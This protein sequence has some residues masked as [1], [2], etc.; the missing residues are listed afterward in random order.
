ML[1]ECEN[2]VGVGLGFF[3]LEFVSVGKEEFLEIRV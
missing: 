1:Y 2:L 3:C